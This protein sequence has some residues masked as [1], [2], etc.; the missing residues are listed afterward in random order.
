MRFRIGIVLASL[1]TA[2][3]GAGKPA[4][5]P[6]DPVVVRVGNVEVRASELAERLQKLHEFERQSFGRTAAEVRR[7]YV[8]KKLLPELLQSEEAR[9]RG[10]ARRAEVRTKTEALL[11]S[12]L[13]ESILS[14]VDAKLTDAEIRAYCERSA[15]PGKETT[16]ASKDCA[17]D[18]L[19]YRIALRR[20]KAFKQLAQLE[21]ELRAR[22]V[23]GK[24]AS[25]LSALVVPERGAIGTR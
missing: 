3:L 14:E 11:V 13:K 17:R 2:P 5:A 1:F 24:D 22:E 6:D 19:S 16:G 4:T 15:T 18:A 12:A 10:F 20:E 25:A 8:E 9:R 21:K 7:A 23:K